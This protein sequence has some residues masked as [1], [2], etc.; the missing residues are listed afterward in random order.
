[1]WQAA[2]GRFG[3]SVWAS[4]GAAQFNAAQQGAAPDRPQL[5]RFSS[6]SARL[7][8]GRARRAAG[9]LSRCAVARSVTQAVK[10]VIMTSMNIWRVSSPILAIAALAALP[11]CSS[12]RASLPKDAPIIGLPALAVEQ[13]KPDYT[14]MV[15]ICNREPEKL[16]AKVKIAGDKKELIYSIAG[17]AAPTGTYHYFTLGQIKQKRRKPIYIRIEWKRGAEQ[18]VK[19]F[20]VSPEQTNN[21]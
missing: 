7:Q 12:S 4:V 9:E 14:L 15:A 2:F 11:G 5:G 1:L 8:L 18:G 16:K 19:Q 20:T 13:G 10:R 6:A 3:H 17:F 21:S